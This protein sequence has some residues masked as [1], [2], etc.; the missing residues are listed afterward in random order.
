M[1]RLADCPGATIGSHTVHHLDLMAQRREVAVRELV[2][3]RLALET[4]VGRTVRTL[5]Y[6]YGNADGTLAA[7]AAAAGYAF[8]FTVEDRAIR[9]ADRPLLL[10]RLGIGAW[11]EAELARRVVGAMARADGAR[12]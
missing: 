5:S 2:E 9:R 6:P 1:A 4:R 8:A 12:E 10:P 7:L 3:S 11:S